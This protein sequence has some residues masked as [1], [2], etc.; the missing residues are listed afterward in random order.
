MFLVPAPPHMP[1][2]AQ[3]AAMKCSI[4]G[5]G[6]SAV[7]EAVWEQ[8]SGREDL[9]KIEVGLTNYPLRYQLT[10]SFDPVPSGGFRFV[11][12]GCARDFIGVGETRDEAFGDWK[13]QIHVSFQTLLRKRRF[14]MDAEDRR[15]WSVLE[16]LIDVPKYRRTTP[17]TI[18]QVGRAQFLRTNR[19]QGITWADHTCDLVA[20]DSMPAA[21]AALLPNQWFEAEVERDPITWKLCKV[22]S[23]SPIAS[24]RPMSMEQQQ[25][26]LQG[27]PNSV[28]KPGSDVE[29]SGT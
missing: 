8:Y 5:S 2:Y 14:E 20:I 23:L 9:H 12:D 21:Y 11:V 24:P 3:V 1:P 6:E 13:E 27:L 7:A 4:S 26:Y 22:L 17:I 18:R 28:E 15:R 19:P 29:D 16:S 25:E 10:G